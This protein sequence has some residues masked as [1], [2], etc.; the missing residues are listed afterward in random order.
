MKNID[1]KIFGTLFFSIFGTVTGVG[2]VVPLLPVYASN[3]G[4]SGVYIGLIFG[5]FSISRTFLLPYFGRQSDKKGRK[6][7]II[8]GLF[9]YTVVSLAFILSNSVESLIAIRFLQGIASAMIMPAVQAYVGDIT[10]SGKEG[11]TMG[12]FNMSMFLD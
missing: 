6:P 1:K 8:I 7:Y 11:F 3:L 4:A 10:P 2:I 5:A 12:L 9:A